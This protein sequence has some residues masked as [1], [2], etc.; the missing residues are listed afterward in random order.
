VRL[1]VVDDHAGFRAALVSAL[2]MVEDL[3]VVGEAADGE[4]AVEAAISLLPD[5]L[6]M[7]LSMPGLS[8]IEATRKLRRSLPRM[9]VV[10]LTAHADPAIEREAVE[11]G[12]TRFLAKGTPFDELVLAIRQAEA[13]IPTAMEEEGRHAGANGATGA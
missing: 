11:A 13:G 7:D 1:L 4:E 12:V 8:G 6:V 2:G 5:V 9:P 10:I 3:E